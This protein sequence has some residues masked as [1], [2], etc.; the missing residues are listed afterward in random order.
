MAYTLP[1]GKQ[2]HVQVSY[3]DSAGNPA[4]VDG[5]VAWDSSDQNIVDVLVDDTD[6]TLAIVRAEGKVG[7][8]Q[9][10]ATADADLGLGTRTLITT[11]DVEVVA[12]EAVAGSITPVGEPEDIPPPS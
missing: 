8:C 7:L 2:V 6:S 10:T 4:V 12:G 5:L 11:M 9:V 3:V 1:V